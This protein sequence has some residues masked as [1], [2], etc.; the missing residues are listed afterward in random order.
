M[1]ADNNADNKVLLEVS[2]L[3]KS[4]APEGGFLGIFGSSQKIPALNGVSLTIHEGEVYGL[5]G[6]SG[7]GKSA[8]AKAIAG[9]ERP[10][11]GKV[12]FMGQ[13]VTE[14]NRARFQG[15]LRY[16]SDDLFNGLTPGDPKN[17]L[18]KLLY[19]VSDKFSE[20]SSSKEENRAWANELIRRVGLEPTD[21]ERWPNQI[22]G[23]QRQRFAIARA[24]VTKPKL[25][26]CDEPVSNLDLQY[27]TQ[28][29]NVLKQV[30]K[31]YNI[32]FLFISHNPSEVRYFTETG[33]VGVMF[34]GRIMEQLPGRDLFDKAAHPYTKTLLAAN[35]APAPVPASA[36]NAQRAFARTELEEADAP[37]YQTL[38]A[39]ASDLSAEGSIAAAS[40]LA[41]ANKPGCPFYNWCPERFDRCPQETP[42]LLTVTRYRSANGEDLP[43]PA[44]QIAG[45][46][47]AACFHY[48]EQ[49]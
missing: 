44:E 30:G 4:Y 32:A 6:E 33:S 43:L 22:S 41:A 3:V 49:P 5:T 25:I 21:L 23:G 34:A 29:L 46:H 35:E 9:I 38:E 8:L 16:V 1:V 37:H 10:D 27:R 39:E 17:R 24:L 31:Q 14:E 20:N 18:D 45:N 36:L 48:I 15:Q 12:L 26:I 2:N 47:R 28:V 40:Q 42:Q 19:R 7:S 11:R 13:T